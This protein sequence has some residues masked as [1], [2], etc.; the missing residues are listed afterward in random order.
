MKTEYKTLCEFL[1]KKAIEKNGKIFS[2]PCNYCK[3][4]FYVDNHC[5]EI[6]NDALFLWYNTKDKSTH[7]EKICIDNE[8]L[9]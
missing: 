2:I 8:M 3:D 4:A 1:I 5:F 9:Q 7:V 6:I